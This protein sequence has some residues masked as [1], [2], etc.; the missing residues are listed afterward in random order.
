[1]KHIFFLCLLTLTASP[2]FSYDATYN[3]DDFL[4]EEQTALLQESENKLYRQYGDNIPSSA[5]QEAGFA[6]LETMSI[7]Q[8]IQALK[9]A[10]ACN[11]DLLNYCRSVP[12]TSIA[13]M[14]CVERRKAVM[15]N[16]CNTTLKTSLGETLQK[17]AIIQRVSLPSGTKL[18]HQ[19]HDN[20]TTS[21]ASVTTTQTITNHG[22]TF[23][24]GHIEFG[25]M[26]VTSG[27][28]HRDASIQGLLFKA[29]ATPLTFHDNGSVRGGILARDATYQKM[30]FKGGSTILFYDNRS[31][32]SGTL[33][34]DT[35]INGIPMRAGTRVF[36]T[37][38]GQLA[39]G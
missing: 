31:I 5:L 22:A 3:F 14:Q 9:I 19:L 34:K 39:S 23:A 37:A 17:N 7:F 4:N 2:A 15:S 35:T 1:M 18:I 11:G 27:I 25:K 30:T 13:M 29:T 38:D 8:R 26:G 10:A 12:Q 16:S 6:L 36:F 24:A 21:I 32:R 28:L 20:A 33:A